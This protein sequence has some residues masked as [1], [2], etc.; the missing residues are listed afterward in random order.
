MK[1][2]KTI[3]PMANILIISLKFF[4]QFKIETLTNIINTVV[5]IGV[6]F[7]FL[8]LRKINELAH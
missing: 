2:N 4:L 1:D 5:S 6:D 8:S 3:T 7:K